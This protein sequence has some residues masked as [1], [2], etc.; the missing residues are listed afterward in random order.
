MDNIISFDQLPSSLLNYLGSF[1]NLDNLAR[2]SLINTR[3]RKIFSEIP[4]IYKMIKKREG[5]RENKELK[6]LEYYIEK[7][8]AGEY[9]EEEQSSILHLACLEENIS[10]NTIKYLIENK[11]DVNYENT[12]QQIPLH[13]ACTNPSI[14]IEVLRLLIENKSEIN[15]QDNS[16]NTPLILLSENYNTSL[17]K[18]QFMVENKADLNMVNSFSITPLQLISRKGQFSMIKYMIENKSDPQ[19]NRPA[20]CYACSNLG[21]ESLEII[22]Y[23]VEFKCDVNPVL[24]DS[25]NSVHLACTSSQISMEILKILVDQKADLNLKG[26]YNQFTPLHF[27]V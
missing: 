8:Y 4:S 1:L 20:L 6:N 22:K 3:N 16:Q 15:K 13:S 21:N 10:A 5:E 17:E 27:L 24:Y 12:L 26:Q 25:C 23:L 18:I 14:T 9:N 7:K 11:G 19:L 2:F